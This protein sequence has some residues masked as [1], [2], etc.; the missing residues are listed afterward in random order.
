M[1]YVIFDLDGTISNLDHRLHHIKKDPQ[2]W[3]EFFNSCDEDGLNDWSYHL[4]LSLS[5]DFE[6]IIVSGRPERTR[7]K[8]E[9]WLLEQVFPFDKLILVRKDGDHTPDEMLKERWLSGFPEREKILF[10]VDDRQ[11]VVDMWRR[12]GL[13]CLQCDAWPELAKPYPT[14]P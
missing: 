1:K 3:E 10:V 11:K 14:K 7:E 12:N 5:A 8:T 13:V 6:I 4:A 2:D 9:A